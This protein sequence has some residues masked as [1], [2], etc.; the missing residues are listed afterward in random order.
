MKTQISKSGQNL[1]NFFI[2]L[3]ISLG[4]TSN[5]SAQYSTELIALTDNDPYNFVDEKSN[6]HFTT[7]YAYNLSESLTEM[8]EDLAIENWMLDE[9]YWGAEEV[10]E[11]ELNIESWMN[12]D[13]Y[14][15]T[16]VEFEL[17]EPEAE[18]ALMIEEWMTNE[19]F[20]GHN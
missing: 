3:L 10:M 5:T 14:W 9:M 8:E 15:V 17:S 1:M 18:E 13:E 20:W 4:L 11:E 19:A 12:D 16:P 6:D 7:E 2:I